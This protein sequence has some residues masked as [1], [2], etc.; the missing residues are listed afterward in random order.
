MLDPTAGD[1][2]G[3]TYQQI[4][5]EAKQ[6]IVEI[7]VADVSRLM[8]AGAAIIDIREFDEYTQ[9]AIEGATFVPRGMLEL[10]INAVVPDIDTPVILYCAGGGR[11]ALAARDLTA[12]GYSNV[13]SLEGGFDGWKTSGAGWEVPGGLTQRQRGQYARHLALPEIGEEGQLALLKARVLLIGAGGLG[14]PVALYL[15]AAGVGTIGIVDS[16]RV[17][18]SN[19][20]RQIM[21]TTQRIG[22]LKVD[23]A[24]QAIAAINPDVT[25]VRH[26]ER[27]VA[28]NVLDILDGYDVIVD[29]ADNFPTRYLLNDASLHTN[30]PVVHGSVYR[31]EG[32]VTV[33][34]PWQGP[35]YRCLFPQPPPPEL[36]PNCATAGVLGVLPGIIGSL[37]A[38]EAIKLVLHLGDSLSGRLLTYDALDQHFMELR[39]ERDPDCAACGR[40]GTR[41]ALVDYDDLC[42]A[43]A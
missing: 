43:Q 13:M 31:F 36:A 38:L 1:C 42:V 27:L 10:R 4:V 37:Q 22:H 40:D 2:V 34:S 17:D 30:T 5:D 6:Q 23:S 9:G 39:L 32:Q 33:F 41:P 11:S 18:I 8:D 12:M 29:G 26:A 15:A 14:S 21:H 25:V 16:D 7:D 24:S 20:Q 35:C 3:R 28:A 19:L